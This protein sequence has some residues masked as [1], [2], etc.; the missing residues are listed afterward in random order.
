MTT[1]MLH[2]LLRYAYLHLICFQP[3]RVPRGCK[4]SHNLLVHCKVLVQHVSRSSST[5]HHVV[6]YVRWSQLTRTLRRHVE[7]ICSIH[8]LFMLLV[9]LW[10]IFKTLSTC[11]LSLLRLHYERHAYMV[12]CSHQ[13]PCGSL[14]LL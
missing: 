6:F 14:L 3:P 10:A 5:Q 1:V 13:S 8:N 7:I 11:L 9:E 12:W 4:R 2:F